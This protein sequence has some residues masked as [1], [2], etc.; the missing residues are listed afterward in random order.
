MT[1]TKRKIYVDK[2]LIPERINKYKNV[3]FINAKIQYFHHII[4]EATRNQL[5]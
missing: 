4:Q 5:Y 3:K 1:N 2:I